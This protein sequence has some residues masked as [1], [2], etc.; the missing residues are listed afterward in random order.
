[1]QR[2]PN[3]RNIP[4]SFHYYTENG[5]TVC[6]PFLKPRDILKCLLSKH[7]W[8]LFGGL[9][10]A[11]GGLQLLETFWRC[12]RNEHASHAVF[13]L[14]ASGAIDLRTTI[15]LMMHG[16]GART[17]SKQPLEI[18]SLLPAL[19]LNTHAPAMDCTCDDPQKYCC[20]SLDDPFAQRLNS[21]HHTYLTHFLMFAFASKRYKKLPGLLLSFTKA[22]SDDLGQICE[23]G[24]EIGGQTFFF[25]VIGLRGDMEYHFKFGLNRTYK[26][27]GT[28][29]QIPCCHLCLAGGPLHPFEDFSSQALWK[30][31]LHSDA[32]W[33]ADFE[34]AFN[35]IPFERWNSGGASQFF[36]SDPFHIF[37]QG[38]GRN[39]IG[40]AIILL[41]LEG[42]FDFDPG[43]SRSVD[44]RLSRAY[45]HF[46]LW[47]DTEKKR[48]T[49]VRSFSKLKLHYPTINSFPWISCKGE[50]TMIII[51]WLRF[52]SQLALAADPSSQLLLLINRAC[53]HA[54]NFQKIHRHG[55][56]LGPKC[57]RTISVAGRSSIWEYAKLANIALQRG[58]TLF[59]M[60]PKAHA[61]HHLWAALDSSAQNPYA[62]NPALYDCS[63]S[64]DF[65]GR[66][67][68]QS[69]RVSAV[70]AEQNV[71]LAYQVKAKLVIQHYAKSKGL[72]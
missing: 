45:S 17:L 36:K 4:N 64:E 13:G 70:N 26:N 8:I 31:T 61:M 53:L 5:R 55:I 37:R 63:T 57:R 9:T 49:S 20:K 50:D 39:F 21:K 18:F 65:V 22:I 34:V 58:L 2:C 27:V 19:G 38:I 51:R 52:V 69:R 54:A 48:A 43:E 32:P 47:C 3:L 25:A 68:R 23:S 67:A 10:P 16:D 11:N 40:S 6:L 56:W 44:S 28:T 1:M 12:F 60:V 15:P 46:T 24:I 59:A 62:M 33:A 14:A 29:N 35:G 41:G 7:P 66:V 30:R 71:L 42:C 72:S